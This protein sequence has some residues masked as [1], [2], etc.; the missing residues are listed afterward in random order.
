MNNI[1]ILGDY[2]P[3]QSSDPLIRQDSARLFD[4]WQNWATQDAQAE[5]PRW[6]NFNPMKF[7]SIL[8]NVVLVQVDDNDAENAQLKLVG[9]RAGMYLPGVDNS[10]ISTITSQ[11]N[12]AHVKL[13]LKA[14]L[15]HRLP[16]YTVKSMAWRSARQRV[17]DCLMMPF[18]HDDKT[19]KVLSLLHFNIQDSELVPKKMR[20]V[21]E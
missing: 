1:D 12:L 9:E 3:L 18:Y 19:T 8:S 16:C 4:M 5:L 7:T 21:S 13:C 17:Y 20:T 15:Q 6:S 10:P 14:C 2:L 11:E